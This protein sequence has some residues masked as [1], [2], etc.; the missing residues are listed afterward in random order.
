[1]TIPYHT[2]TQRSWFSEA[3][4]VIIITGLISSLASEMNQQIIIRFLPQQ[5]ENMQTPEACEDVLQSWNTAFEVP[6]RRVRQFGD[7]GWIVRVD[8]TLSAGA[9]RQLIKELND[10]PRVEYA[11]GNVFMRTMKRD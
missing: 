11:E 4:M 2:L 7:R 9:L 6:L 5:W 1:M 3:I 8:A 10:D